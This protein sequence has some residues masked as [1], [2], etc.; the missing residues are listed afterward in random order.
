M[1]ALRQIDEDVYVAPQ[2]SPETMAQA[3]QAGFKAVVNNRPD[4][5][6]GPDQP[7]SAAIEAAA[8][9]VGLEYEHL[10]VNPA[11]IGPAEVQA[12]AQLLQTLPRP[13]LLFCRSGSRSANLYGAAKALQEGV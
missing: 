3:A 5:E 10:P 2:L 13:L 8:K 4:F 1:S 6:H 9:A 7:S 12:M 11:S